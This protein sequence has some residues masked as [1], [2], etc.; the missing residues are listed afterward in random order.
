MLATTTVDELLEQ[1]YTQDLEQADFA[2]V[3][4]HIF[5]IVVPILKEEGVQLERLLRD[6]LGR[7]QEL[8]SVTAGFGLMRISTVICP[9]RNGERGVIFGHDKVTTVIFEDGTALKDLEI[10]ILRRVEMERGLLTEE[11]LA[12]LE[13][14]RNVKGKISIWVVD[15]PRDHGPVEA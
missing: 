8:D 9:G 2:L 14:E 7:E 11:I 1:T 10:F 5:L 6:L 3:S 13:I 15:H 4:N 12:F